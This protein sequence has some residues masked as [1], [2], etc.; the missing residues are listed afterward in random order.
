MAKGYDHHELE[1]KWQAYW[2]EHRPFRAMND[3]SKPK[4][5]CLDMFPYPSGSGLHVGH[6]E[7]YTATD[8][9]S[10]YKRMKGFNVLH[11]MGWDAF[12]LPAEQ[13]AVKTGVHPALTTAQNI[14]TFKR[15]MKRVGLSYDWERELSTT[16]P[17][18]YRWTQWIFLQLYKRGLAYVAEVPVNW[19]PA[20]GTVL[21]NEEI[22]DGKSEVGGFDVI[23]KPMRQW[24]LKIT[25][26][27][28]RLLEDLKL[29][30]WPASTL[31]MQKNWIG[32]SIGAEV[33]FALAD[34][35]GTIRVFTTRP[36]T[37]FGATYMVLAPE[38]P[39]VD[40]VTGAP[41]KA[42]VTA[43]REA[44]ARKS[45]L[46]RQEL[47][48][49]KTGVFTGGYAINPV[50]GERL[51]VWLAD[52]V[53]MSYGT[54][55]I[56]AVPAHDER[57]WTFAKTYQ[58]PIREVIQGGHVQEAAFVATDRGTVVNSA[59]PDGSLSL[60]G[61]KPAEAIPA[62]TAWLEQ[63]GTG[64]KAINYKL[65][66]W[67]FARQ[68]YWGEPFPIVWV[69]GESRPL[70]EEQ[71]PL[72]LPET[73]NF[74]PSG[75][76]ES[77]LANLEEWLVTTDPQTGKPARRETNT[78]PQWAG[79]CWYYLRFADPKN[80]K[81]LV[82]PAMERY[83][84][85]V[86]LYVGGSE[87]AVLHLLYS[88]FWH[89][90]LYDIG[91]VSTPEPFKKLVHQ[92]IVLGE[93]NQKMSKSR[94]NVVNPD[95]MMDQFGADAVRLYEMFMGPLEAMKPW[96]SRGVEGVTRFLE[97]VWRLM[98]TEDGGL[99]SSVVTAAPSVE[100][101]RLLHQT[102]KKVSEDIDELRFNTAIAQMMVFTNEMTKADQRP[103]ALLEPFVLLLSPF[104][105]HVAEELWAILGHAP[106][107]SQQTWPVYDPA[108]TV[109]DRLTIPVQINGKLRGKI[110][111]AADTA[112]DVVER[113]A[114][115]T[116]AEWLQGSEPKKVIYVEKKLVNFVL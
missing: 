100:Q 62:I 42:A 110:E 75:S 93:D 38:H 58:L 56:M 11:P 54:G 68:R 94:G 80:A 6:L 19:C 23:R 44:A 88:R 79:S 89:K 12:G 61:M 107:V 113:T 46:Q 15:Q 115:E 1:A 106:S 65:R 59:L 104:A 34:T 85:P 91:V 17:D 5:Y 109:S 32:R 71:L 41:Q 27:A 78:M 111:V 33:D 52:Y 55:A 102:I 101:Q 35:R 60:N 96:S 86:D 74:K 116:V 73:S 47:D 31:E 81:Q 4:F 67:L 83:W 51:P 50:N 95:D 20:L 114:R 103:R 84:M 45:D 48:K 14:A 8:I 10:R 16:D 92:G 66:D 43:Y 39:L 29:V 105:P 9:V 18:Y 53:L 112:R 25:A 76:G 36:D 82:D 21:A 63:K 26:Y 72:I 7:G 64:K 22:V 13:Y 57:D 99:S 108:L 40:V 3:S 37:L 69:D 30:E 87:H 70:P 28:D 2:E 24:V 97:R 49:E 98:V 77:P 90:V